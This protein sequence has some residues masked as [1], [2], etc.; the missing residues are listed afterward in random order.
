MA[1]NGVSQSASLAA[2][3]T[4]NSV[5]KPAHV[6]QSDAAKGP[7]FSERMG[8]AL[9]DVAKAQNS[10][11]EAAKNFEMGKTDDLAAVMV[12]Q[13]VSSLSF[14]MTLQVRNKALTAYRDIMN[15]PV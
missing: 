9:Q 3:G 10:A 11:S 1:I 15:M 6:G 7:S 2:L 5:A 12:E 14:Q 13:Q 8:G 4:T